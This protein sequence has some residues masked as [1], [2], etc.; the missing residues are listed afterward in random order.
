MSGGES[1][2]DLAGEV[3]GLAMKVHS[4]LGPGFLESVYQNALVLEL[5][6]HGFEVETEKP[7]QV[8]YEGEAVGNFV[9]DMVI[10]GELIVENKAV[11]CLM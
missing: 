2:Y 6:R 9:A 11:G 8:I 5:R 7:L 1:E 3:I 4:V 10:N